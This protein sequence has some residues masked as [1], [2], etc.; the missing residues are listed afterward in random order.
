M[1]EWIPKKTLR[2]QLTEELIS[3]QV[4]REQDKAAFLARPVREP[5]P[6]YEPITRPV[7]EPTTLPPEVLAE[8]AVEPIKHPWVSQRMM[9]PTPAQALAQAP[10]IAEEEPEWWELPKE[11]AES[12][13]GEVGEAIAKVPIL[14]KILE[15][16]GKIFEWV[17]EHLEK[18]FAATILSWASPSLPWKKG[19]S[20]LE[21]E[22]REYDAWKAPTYVKG[23][24]EFAMPL[25]WLPWIG[26]AAKGAKAVGIGGKAARA[27]A[28]VPKA[29]KV[30]LPSSKV[31]DD[32]LFKQDFFRTVAG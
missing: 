24:A 26:W 18:P 8:P 9:E 19:E 28:V 14:P 29:G 22:K 10:T 17:H 25:W 4:Q 3:I 32:V 13:M 27:A 15:P 20:W 7:I 5:R 11:W 2:D 21:H 1:P 23:L 16:V 30:A 12:V 31:L 6:E